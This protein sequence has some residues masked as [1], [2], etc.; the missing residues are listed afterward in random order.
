MQNKI[1][2]EEL[3]LLLKKLRESTLDQ[4]TI[5][6]LEGLVMGQQLLVNLITQLLNAKGSDKQT[7]LKELAKILEIHLKQKEKNNKDQGER[8]ASSDPEQNASD[9]QDVQET[10]KEDP[11]SE[12]ED[13]EEG[14]K[15]SHPQRKN[16]EYNPVNKYLHTCASQGFRPGSI[17]PACGIGKLYPFRQKIIPILIG[18][19]PLVY[20]EHAL[21]VLR[22]NR[23]GGFI[24]ARLPEEVRVQGR[25]LASATAMLSVLHYRMNLPFGKLEKLQEW[26]LQG[27]SVAQMWSVLENASHTLIPLL[28]EMKKVAANAH[29]FYTDDTTG[30]ILEHYSENKVNR[31]KAFNGRKKAPKERVATYSSLIIAVIE[32][33]CPVHLY[34]HGRQYAGENLTIILKNRV[35]CIGPPIHMKDALSQNIPVGIPVI[36]A[37]CNAHALR[38]FKDISD[39]FKEECSYILERYRKVYKNDNFCLEKNFSP[40]ARLEYHKKHS[41]HLMEEIKEYLKNGDSER[42]IEPNSSLGSASRYFLSHYNGLTACLRIEGAPFD[43]NIAERALKMIIGLRKNSLFYKTEQGAE[44]GSIFQSVLYTAE[45]CKKNV[46]EYLTAVFN[47]SGE[48]LK[49]PSGW[50]P[51]TYE[52]SLKDLKE[53]TIH[54]NSD[55]L[56]T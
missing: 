7:L 6:L 33:G 42:K 48:V 36:E 18:Q 30:R 37:K 41:S 51:W 56:M 24:Q 55:A 53:P 29:L 21:E 14:N 32:G 50:L 9:L 25:A 54:K 35:S 44:V 19:T 13:S 23:C 2:Q 4:Q 3:S 40:E 11:L 16:H 39:I 22:C 5:D 26:A 8:G 49:N 10:A 45:A 12:K 43:N 20:E 47:N 46:L 38:K 34:Y 15:K 27:C 52:S 17:C 28:E 31:E 1:S